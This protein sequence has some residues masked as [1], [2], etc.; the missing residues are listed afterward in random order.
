MV[1]QGDGLAHRF[2]TTCEYERELEAERDRNIL[3]ALGVAPET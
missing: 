3:L 2:K 1:R